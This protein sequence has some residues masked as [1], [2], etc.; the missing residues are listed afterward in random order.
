LNHNLLS[1]F[2]V[3]K[4]KEIFALHFYFSLSSTLGSMTR[5]LVLPL[6]QEK[7]PPASAIALIVFH[8]MPGNSASK[9]SSV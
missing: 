1:R 3:T 4:R 8:T 5:R 9:P 7:L 2:A 6:G